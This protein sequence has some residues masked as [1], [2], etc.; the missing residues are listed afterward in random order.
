MFRRIT[1]ELCAGWLA[2]ADH[3]HFIN[4][5]Q[6]GAYQV[7]LA[8]RA[9]QRFVGRHGNSTFWNSRDDHIMARRHIGVA[10]T[11]HCPEQ[12]APTMP[13][14]QLEWLHHISSIVWVTYVRGVLSYQ[15]RSRRR[16]IL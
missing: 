4:A 15:D 16:P 11:N 10:P 1:T 2:E 9:Q 7:P 14:N 8:A 6:R 3:G 5:G 13:F 12:R